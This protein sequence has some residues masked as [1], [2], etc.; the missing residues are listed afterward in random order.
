[1]LASGGAGA[2]ELTDLASAT[3]TLQAFS[4]DGVFTKLADGPI[5][6]L[7]LAGSQIAWTQGAVAYTAPLPA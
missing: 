7:R 1:V 6:G 2:Y 5:E 4:P 3:T